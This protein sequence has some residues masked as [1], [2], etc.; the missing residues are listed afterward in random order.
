MYNEWG[1]LSL[2]RGDD[3]A[4]NFSKFALGEYN[5]EDWFIGVAVDEEGRRVVGA[6]TDSTLYVWDFLL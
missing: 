2:L 5:G 6:R 1:Q 4:S 3:L